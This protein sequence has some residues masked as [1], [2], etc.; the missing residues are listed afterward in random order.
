MDHEPAHELDRGPEH[1]VRAAARPRT[2]DVRRSRAE[3]RRA[4]RDGGARRG[5]TGSDAWVVAPAMATDAEWL[6]AEAALDDCDGYLVVAVDPQ[7]GEVDAHGPYA[8]L[9]AVHAAEDM[10]ATFLRE[11]LDDVVVRIV[12]WHEPQARY[13]A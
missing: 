7:T 10:R 4:D 9:G 12:R 3:P 2:P 11:E 13:A 6:D 1:H 5:E 8:G